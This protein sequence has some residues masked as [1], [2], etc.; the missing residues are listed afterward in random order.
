M[1]LV[2]FVLPPTPIA[3]GKSSSARLSIVGFN[4]V[5]MRA[6][7]VVVVN[8]SILLFGMK[9]YNLHDVTPLE[10]FPGEEETLVR[11]GRGLSCQ[12]FA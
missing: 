4:V 6:F 1:L 5:S 8:S 9:R 11:P 12:K 7:V 2:S 3:Q 10:N